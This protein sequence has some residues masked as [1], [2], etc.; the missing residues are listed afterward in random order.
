M[1]T[2][3]LTHA[4][5]PL[6]EKATSLY[7][8]VFPQWEREPIAE[9]ER[10]I[11]SG[12]S[13][14]ILLYKNDQ[15]LGMSLTELYPS[16]SFAL[17][18]YLFIAPSHQGQG[19]G[20]MLCNELFDFF[21]SHPDFKWLLVEAESEPEGFYEQLGFFRLNFEYLSPHYDDMQSTPMALMCYFKFEQNQLSEYQAC[22]IVEHIFLQS[23]Y[24]KPNDPRLKIQ[25]QRILSKEAL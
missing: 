9:I 3:Q 2:K 17:L 22:D 11:N 13:R 16:L 10:A 18:G 19:L 5:G 1:Q 4:V 24:L 7:Y 21:D 23:Y 25:R 8:E 20:K 6:W 14:C 15:V 12:Q